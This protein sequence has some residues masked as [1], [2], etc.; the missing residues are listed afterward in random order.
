MRVDHI[1]LAI[2]AGAETRCRPFWHAAGFA[3]IEKP[4]AL[5]AR[6]GLWLRQGGVEVHLGVDPNFTPATKAHPGLA[7]A[8]LDPLAE[9]L[10]TLGA[11]VDWD[12]AITHRRRFFTQDPV[13]NRIEFL[14]D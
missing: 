3:E 6:G 11:P 1:Q 2:P 14:E 8:D 10:T 12:T 5:R 9:A 4:A 13:G 7:T